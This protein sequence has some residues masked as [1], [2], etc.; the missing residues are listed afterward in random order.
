[1]DE[2]GVE[3]GRLSTTEKYSAVMSS[4]VGRPRV[5]RGRK[6]GCTLTE[7]RG[8]RRAVKYGVRRLEMSE[9]G[10]PIV[11]ISQLLGKAGL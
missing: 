3:V 4:G 8:S 6:P 10:W 9:R 7:R 5:A 2:E 1:M 11:D